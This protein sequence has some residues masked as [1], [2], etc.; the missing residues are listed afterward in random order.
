MDK[1]ELKKYIGK[2]VEVIHTRIKPNPVGQLYRV[3]DNQITLQR[4]KNE[5]PYYFQLRVFYWNEIQNV[6]PK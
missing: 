6:I 3:T 2:Q 1:E 5:K 4:S